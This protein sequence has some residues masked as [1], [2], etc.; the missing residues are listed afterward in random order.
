MDLIIFWSFRSSLDFICSLLFERT[1]HD[2][3]ARPHEYLA[4][5]T[6]YTHFVICVAQA[7]ISFATVWSPVALDWNLKQ[8]SHCFIAKLCVLIFVAAIANLGMGTHRVNNLGTQYGLANGASNQQDGRYMTNQPVL[9]RVHSQCA[10]ARYWLPAEPKTLRKDSSRR[11]KRR[12]WACS[13]T[14]PSGPK[15]K[16]KLR[17]DREHE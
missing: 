15:P 1:L 3:R 14:C 6:W 9:R 16:G 2:L 13:N 17:D 11:R 4:L 7:F 12:T 10:S 5:H 8:S